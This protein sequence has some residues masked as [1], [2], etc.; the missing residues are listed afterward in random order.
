MPNHEESG[1]ACELRHLLETD[2]PEDTVLDRVAVQRIDQVAV[3]TLAKP[4]AQNA[5]TLASWRRVKAVFDELAE[6]PALRAVVVRGA[7]PRAFAAGADIKEFPETRMTAAA[8]TDYNESIARALRAVAALPM[9]VIAAVHGLAVGGGCELATAC[10]VRI[11]TADARLGIPIGKLGVILGYTETTAVARLIGPAALKYLLFS[12]NLIP[13]VEAKAIG[14]VQRIVPPGML[15]AEVSDLII[16]I[17]GQSAVTMRAA[18]L[19]A[20][21]Y[22]RPLTE[23]DTEL[24]TR[25]N[26]EAYEGADLKEGV[27]AFTE[28]RAP[29]FEQKGDD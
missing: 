14:L 18:K 2:P 1:F 8:A 26:V 27:A 20:G 11:A 24:L 13:A 21:M 15:A 9:P 17:C 12:G 5:L 4:E 16:R 10:D 28:R 6:Q 3:V 7:G 25:L 29:M 22:G 19:V 23:A